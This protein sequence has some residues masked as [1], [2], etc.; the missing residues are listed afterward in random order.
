LRRVWVSIFILDKF[1]S[2]RQILGL[3]T[4]ESNAM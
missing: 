3:K 1:S 4:H 2:T